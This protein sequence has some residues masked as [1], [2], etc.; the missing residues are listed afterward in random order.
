MAVTILRKNCM[1]GKIITEISP[2]SAVNKV[3]VLYIVVLVRSGIGG[4]NI[5][6]LAG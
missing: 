6:L 3:H 4:Y 2:C 1:G 5:I